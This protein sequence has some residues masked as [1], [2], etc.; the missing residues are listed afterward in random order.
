MKMTER[1]PIPCRGRKRPGPGEFGA[2]ALEMGSRTGLVGPT[3]HTIA[4]P[5]LRQA[6]IPPSMC[7]A[8]LSPE[9]CAACTA[10]AERSPNAQ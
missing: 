3:P 5:A 10:I 4:P 6:S 1:G 2:R 9:S 7:R 8:P